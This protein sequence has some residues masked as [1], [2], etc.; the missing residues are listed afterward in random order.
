MRLTRLIRL[1]RRDRIQGPRKELVG[2]HTNIT[3]VTLQ[4]GSLRPC[5]EA[6]EWDFGACDLER[7]ACE[8]GISSSWK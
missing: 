7:V 6:S 4:E 1:S 5:R 8:N 2:N 3:A